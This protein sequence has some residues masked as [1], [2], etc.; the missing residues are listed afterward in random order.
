MPVYSQ[1]L[2]KRV[3][4]TLERREG[5]LRQIAHRFLV[6]LSFVTRLLEHRRLTGSLEPKPHGGGR[7]PALGPDDLERLRNLIHEKPDATLEELRQSLGVTC[8]L[9][10]ISRAVRD[11]LKITRKKKDLHAQERDNPKVE[12]KRD[13]FR[14]E[15]AG[16]DPQR[17]VFVDESGANTAM[18]RTYG[19]APVGERVHGAAPGHWDT[20]TLIC[21]LRLSGVTAPVIFEGATD[22]A[23]FESY[24]EQ[25][26]V[27]Q[28]RPGDVVIWDNLKPHKAKP[29]VEAVERAGACVV[30][31]PPWSPDLTPIEEM[32]S[33]VKGALRS[34]AARTT[35]AVYEA[36]GSALH[37]VSLEDVSGW[38]RSRASYA[39][40]S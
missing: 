10:A 40:Q 12:R 8:S 11:K 17:L 23:A 20:V 38:F 2:R 24:V 30:P 19:R 15:V 9:M 13:E 27:P 6:S 14:E 18:T 7:P 39:I 26:L 5:S 37:D 28:L 36:I 16:F 29:A 33:K 22:T 1:D 3:F 21:G 31:L 25:V 35:G 34:A 32:F 4:D